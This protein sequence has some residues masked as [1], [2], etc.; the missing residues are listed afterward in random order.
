MNY[1]ARL[2]IWFPYF[3]IALL[4]TPFISLFREIRPGCLN[5]GKGWG[6][7][8]RLIRFL[9][10]FDT[11]DN[12]LPPTWWGTVKWLYRNKLYGLCIY[13]LSEF[14]IPD[15]IH[16]CG[17]PRINKNNGIEGRFFAYAGNGVFQ[18]KLVK[19][20]IGNYGVMLNFGWELDTIVKTNNA[21][22]AMFMFSPRIVSLNKNA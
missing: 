1:M 20:L 12:A 6:S 11:P 2:L 19:R 4:F 15:Q 9:S 3:I 7:G 13:W 8:W 17:D 10:L 5:N 22:W 16:A 21:A 14:V 18:Y